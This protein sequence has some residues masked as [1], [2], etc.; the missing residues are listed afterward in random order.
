M[1]DMFSELTLIMIFAFSFSYPHI[2][3]YISNMDVIC[4]SLGSLILHSILVQVLNVGHSEYVCSHPGCC[5]VAT[6]VSVRV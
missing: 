1:P 5:K 2:Q 6:H 4:N 3:Q